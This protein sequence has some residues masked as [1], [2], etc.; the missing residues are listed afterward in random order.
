M[1][2][3][4]NNVAPYHGAWAELWRAY[5]YAFG[6]M[7]SDAVL[8]GMAESMGGAVCVALGLP[9]SACGKVRSVGRGYGVPIT[10][11]GQ[12]WLCVVKDLPVKRGC[13]CGETGFEVLLGKRSLYCKPLAFGSCDV[14]KAGYVMAGAA[15][16]ILK[17]A[18]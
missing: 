15:R 12:V 1:N 7:A 14:V 10:F 11:G 5:K 9:A 4:L 3:V 16:V 2:T 18:V 13:L 8:R 6:G 17:G